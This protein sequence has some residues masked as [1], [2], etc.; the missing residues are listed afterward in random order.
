MEENVMM[1][2]TEFIRKIAREVA[3]EEMSGMIN[4]V[5][6]PGRLLSDLIDYKKACELLGVTKTTLHSYINAGKLTKHYVVDGGKPYLSMSE[7]E[8]LMRK[9]KK[10]Q[11]ILTITHFGTKGNV[12]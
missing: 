2:L 6:R 5:S 8:N 7:I 10:N 1:E 12:A 9:S 11:T 3:K 4:N